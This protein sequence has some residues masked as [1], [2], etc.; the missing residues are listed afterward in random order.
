ME[1]LTRKKI[2]VLRL[3]M[4]ENIPPRAS[5]IFEGSRDQD[6]AGSWYLVGYSETS[7]DY[8]VYILG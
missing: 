4:E 3:D 8:R 2:R 6:G 5:I 7:K 1:N